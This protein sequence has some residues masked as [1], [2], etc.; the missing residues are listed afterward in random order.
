MVNTPVIF[1]AFNRPYLTQQVLAALVSQTIRPPVVI[2]FSDGPR[3]SVDETSVAAVRALLRNATALEI[4]LVEWGSNYGCVRNIVEGISTVLREFPAAIIVEDDVLPSPTF[5]EAMC[6]LLEHYQAMPNV[7]SVG[8]YPCLLPSALRG[9]AEDV[10]L[11]PRFSCWGW[12]TWADRWAR[13]R[14]RILTY[15]P[16]LADPPAVPTQKGDDMAAAARM[17]RKYPG[18]Y[19]DYPI[20]LM[21]QENHW[22]HAHTKAYLTNNIGLEGGVNYRPNPRLKTFLAQTNPLAQQVPSRFPEVALRPEVATAI[23]HFFAAR[24]RAARPSWLDQA[25]AY[26]LRVMG[27]SAV[28]LG[29]LVVHSNLL[30]W[31]GSPGSA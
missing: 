26:A 29:L 4:Q 14:D 10:I 5:Y 6:R 7:F 28:L 25:Y 1:F 15:R 21:S 19:W 12:A 11:S 27:R 20:A 22:L 2:A 31:I 23:R 16:S 8:G 24:D 13:V 3:S 17:V 9:Y 30:A 18:R